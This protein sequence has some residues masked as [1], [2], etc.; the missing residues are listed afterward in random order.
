MERAD[1]IKH[2]VAI[3]KVKA[4]VKKTGV[5]SGPPNRD[6]NL[7]AEISRV[8]LGILM[9]TAGM[10]GLGGLLTLFF[11][12]ASE[13]SPLTLFYKWLGSITGW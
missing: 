7:E 4:K 10:F 3:A 1:P 11:A 5:S 6:Q 12:L 9:I 8:G 2:V 13:K